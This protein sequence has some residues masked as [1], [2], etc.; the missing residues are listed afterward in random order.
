MKSDT[1]TPPVK[2]QKKSDGTHLELAPASCKNALESVLRRTALSA[3]TYMPT[4]IEP[5]C[6]WVTAFWCASD[7]GAA[8]RVLARNALRTTGE[9]RIMSV[10]SSSKRNERTLPSLGGGVSAD[11]GEDRRGAMLTKGQVTRGYF[12]LN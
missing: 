2:P 8:T 5:R 4:Y 1:V 3:E 9:G 6:G 12:R 7:F 11:A 10:G